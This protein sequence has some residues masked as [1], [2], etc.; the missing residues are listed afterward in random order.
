MS[1]RPSSTVIRRRCYEYWKQPDGTL[2]CYLCD[3]IMD[4]VRDKWEAEHEI[5]HAHGGSDEPPNVKPVCI[6]CH[7]RK[8]HE[9]R[10]RIDKGR[11]QRDK[12]LG[13][14]RPSGF[15]GWRRFDGSVVYA[16]ER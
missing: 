7:R 5:V 4:P 6:P 8:T 10:K 1:R 9:D 16:R 3:G 14:K 13:F 12:H 11:R 2:N 15:R